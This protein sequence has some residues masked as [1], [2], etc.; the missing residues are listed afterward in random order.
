MRDN[1]LQRHSCVALN[2]LEQLHE[3]VYGK[4]VRVEKRK[5]R[6]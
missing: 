4:I 2:A 1:V 5:R 6:C 3:T